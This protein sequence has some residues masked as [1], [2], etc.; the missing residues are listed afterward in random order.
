MKLKELVGKKV[1]R[2]APYNLGNGNIDRSFMS[3]RDGDIVE[4]LEV[5]NDIPIVKITYCFPYKKEYI[6]GLSDYNDDNWADATEVW[7]RINELN[8]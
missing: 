4:C 7:N 8:K 6:R 1:I 2:T 5:V 3:M